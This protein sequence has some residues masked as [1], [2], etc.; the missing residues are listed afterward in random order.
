MLQS[1][2]IHQP[3]YQ[4]E[5]AKD[6]IKGLQR[7]LAALQQSLRNAKIPVIVL[8]EGLDASGKGSLIAKTIANLDPRG[9]RVH[10]TDVPTSEDMR[11]PVLWPFWCDLPLQGEMSLLDRSWY[12]R[13]IRLGQ[14]DVEMINTFE[15]QLCDDG[16]LVLKFFLN[17]GKKEQRKRLQKL[18]DNPA[19]SWRVTRE[20]WQHYLDYRQR[21]DTWADLLTQ[22]NPSYAPW[23]VIWNEEK[24]DGTIE[25]LTTIRDAI[26]TAIAQGAPTGHHAPLESFPLLPMA[27]LDDVDLSCTVTPEAYRIALKAE[28]AKIQELH[29]QLYRKKI[30]V[31]LCF[32]GWDAAGK[33][34]A[35]RRLSSAMDPRGFDVI[36]VAAPSKEELARHYLWRFWK[37]VPKDGHI[38]I[39]DR[40]WYGRVMVERLEGFTPASRWERAYQEM[41]EFEAELTQWGAVVL[42][43]WVHID[44]DEQLKRFTNRQ[45]TPE[46]RYK[47][48]E[49]D[50]RNREK[51]DAYR[52]AVDEMLA[53]TSTE[54]APWIV[55]E[56][57][58]KLYARLKVLRTVRQALEVRLQ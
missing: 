43:F 19:T 53:K 33:G 5:T 47:I 30:P 14:D 40:T 49:E 56:G 32:E 55:V 35:I 12:N 45:E 39:F 7:E 50:W 8:F 1:P 57:N 42:K 37:N 27:P 31:V 58:D 44:K 28:K 54:N 6:I 3:L 2:N 16:Y 51:W 13:I 20:D 18:A 10:S 29:S 41:N 4:K 46:K 15:R 9:Y 21:A 24:Y 23:H 34:G 17:I 22:T 11:R 36:P 26:Q 38:A 25:V 52:M 48:T